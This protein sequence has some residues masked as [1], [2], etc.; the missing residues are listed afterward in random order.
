MEQ[1]RGGGWEDEAEVIRT[2]EAAVME[3]CVREGGL[4]VGLK[5]SY[6]ELPLLFPVVALC[7]RGHMGLGHHADEVPLLLGGLQSVPHRLLQLLPAAPL[8]VLLDE[9]ALGQPLAVVQHHC[10]GRE[11]SRPSYTSLKFKGVFFT[12][13]PKLC[14]ELIHPSDDKGLLSS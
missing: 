11:S 2:M 7:V 5:M 3:K 6:Q 9:L 1:T 4:G 12:Q 13:E 10:G 14:S 8:P